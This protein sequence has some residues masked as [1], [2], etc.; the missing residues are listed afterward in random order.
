MSDSRLIDAHIVQQFLSENLSE[1]L[2]KER[3]CS[4]G[5]DE[6]LISRYLSELRRV[7]NAR[8]QTMG[9]VYLVTGGVL[10]FISCIL[11]IVNPVP[12][13]YYW[14]LYGLT[15]VAILLACYGLY[16]IFE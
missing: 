6:E 9:F 12:E 3:L 7:K 1:K 14:F 15:S 13:F 5:Y 16:N 11:A 8:R 10:G 4:L 2:I